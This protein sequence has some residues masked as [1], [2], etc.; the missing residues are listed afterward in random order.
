MTLREVI[1]RP[2]LRGHIHFACAIVAPFALVVLLVVAQSPAAY[3]SAAIFGAGLI[4][5]FSVSAAY[6]LVPWPA[7]AHAIARRVD[8]STI[9]LAIGASYTPFCLLALPLPWGIP[10]LVAVW[11]LC[12]LGIGL[13][14]TWPGAP[15][16]LSVGSYLVVGWVALVTIH[17]LSTAISA[18]ALAAMVGAGLLY[19]LGALAYATRW[20]N[21]IPRLIGHHEVFHLLVA[22]ASAVLYGV[23]ALEVLPS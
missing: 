1:E 17:P 10:I 22:A 11:T 13:K 14:L 3:V 16:W 9:F 21:P 2:L 15:L 12:A 20:P 23:V 7:K 5:L 8:Q 4:L 19:S 18:V 6:H